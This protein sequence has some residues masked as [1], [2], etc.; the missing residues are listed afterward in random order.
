[1]T[2]SKSVE[3]SGLTRNVFAPFL[4]GYYGVRSTCEWCGRAPRVLYRYEAQDTN[5]RRILLG[6]PVGAGKPF[7]NVECFKAYS[8]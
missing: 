7:C 8:L 1:M 4:Y 2:K 6:Q 3:V 5:G